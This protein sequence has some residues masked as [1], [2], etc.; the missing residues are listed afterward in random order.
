MEF[1]KEGLESYVTDSELEA[2]QG[3]WREYGS[4]IRI[5]ILRAGG[6]NKKYERI[7]SAI[8]KPYQRQI[9][10]GTIDSDVTRTLLRELY[11]KAVVVDW[12]G[13]KDIK[14]NDVPC[15]SENV[16]G[17]FEAVPDLFD[18]VMTDATTIATFADEEVVSA[19][20]ELGNS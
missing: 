3:V 20:E 8:L 16:E 14:G 19:V 12:I 18:E 9:S 6:S 15:T 11:A 17:L 10:R 7:G 4:G 13:V 2:T 1:S 5:R